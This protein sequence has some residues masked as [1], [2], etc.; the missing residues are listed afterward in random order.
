MRYRHGVPMAISHSE[1]F[2]PPLE[3][4]GT[5]RITIERRRPSVPDRRRLRGADLLFYF[6]FALGVSLTTAMLIVLAVRVFIIG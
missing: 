4:K 2:P 5:G 6:T 3:P 1:T